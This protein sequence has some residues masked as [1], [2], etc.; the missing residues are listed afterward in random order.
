M[1]TEVSAEGESPKSLKIYVEQ[2]K[3]YLQ[4]VPLSRIGE[5][6]W[7]NLYDDDVMRRLLKRKN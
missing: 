3:G 2:E 5:K 4:Y 6:L 1:L 7:A